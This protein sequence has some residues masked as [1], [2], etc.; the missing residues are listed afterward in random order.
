MENAFVAAF[1]QFLEE[2]E[3]HITGLE[4]LQDTLADTRELEKQL[5]E[6]ENRHTGLVT[7]L[8]RYMEENTQQVQDQ[9]EYSRRFSEMDAACKNAEEQI[10]ILQ[11]IL[12]EQ[13]EKKERAR[14]SE[15]TL[16]K[17]S[18]NLTKFDTSLWDA[19]VENVTVSLDKTLTFLFWGGTEIAI[20]LQ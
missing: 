15:E 3:K 12:L 11:K 10:S 1:N 19:M 5:N 14:R 9:T 20:P 17:C 16:R 7:D 8:R 6:Q 4:R 18:G 2:K 13:A